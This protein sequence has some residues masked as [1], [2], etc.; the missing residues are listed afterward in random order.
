MSKKRNV[1]KHKKR[2]W[3]VGDGKDDTDEEVDGNEKEN[4]FFSYPC[5]KMKNFINN[6]ILIGSEHAVLAYVFLYILVVFQTYIINIFAFQIGADENVVFGYVCVF[7]DILD[8]VICLIIFFLL[9][10][11]KLEDLSIDHLIDVLVFIF[12]F[13]IISILKFAAVF[14]LVNYISTC[15]NLT[16]KETKVVHWLELSLLFLF[17]IRGVLQALLFMNMVMLLRVARTTQNMFLK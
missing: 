3:N 12:I 2:R 9:V 14:L 10:K 13:I 4:H 7:T 11:T 6:W 5:K 15:S 16:D 8:V 1:D 17:L